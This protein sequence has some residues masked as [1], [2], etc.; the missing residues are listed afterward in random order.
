MSSSASGNANEIRKGPQRSQSQEAGGK[1]E[2]SGYSSQQPTDNGAVVAP[3]FNP[4]GS[5]TGVPSFPAP[6]YPVGTP[7]SASNFS[8]FPPPS[9]ISNAPPGYPGG[10]Q[11]PP[12]NFPPVQ[13]PQQV[14]PAGPSPLFSAPPPPPPVYPTAPL[15]VRPYQISGGPISPEFY[16]PPLHSNVG[17][18]EYEANMMRLPTVNLCNT[19]ASQ[20]PPPR[21]GYSRRSGE[22]ERWDTKNFGFEREFPLRFDHTGVNQSNLR[23]LTSGG[24]EENSNQVG[25]VDLSNSNSNGNGNEQNRIEIS[26][27][28]HN[29]DA[30]AA[31]D[32]LEV[33]SSLVE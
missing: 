19:A 31:A 5:N 24:T 13:Q 8:F 27:A 6:N 4:L 14:Y 7:T 21:V 20:P 3:T 23:V 22:A 2:Y 33:S 11:P 28:S 30:S 26:S 15:T 9:Q 1:P 32:E 16:S 10:M 25:N 29:H 12:T 18:S 17:G